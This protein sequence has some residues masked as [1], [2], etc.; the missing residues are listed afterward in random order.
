[1]QIA[2]QIC[3]GSRILDTQTRWSVEAVDAILELLCNRYM[4]LSMADRVK[5]RSDM[6]RLIERQAEQA[7]KAKLTV[8]GK[9][10]YKGVE[11]TERMKFLLR[12]I[13]NSQA[14]VENVVQQFAV[15]FVQ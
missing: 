12:Q 7:L 3:Q 4:S 5:L 9:L 11:R 1:M 8:F 13:P 15:K 6:I 2:V 14:T 10:K